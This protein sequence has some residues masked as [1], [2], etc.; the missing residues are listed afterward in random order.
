MRLLVTGGAGFIGSN[1]V[2]QYLSG[3]S[4]DEIINLDLLTYAGN[5][6]NL[7][8]VGDNPKY[9]FVRGD[10]CDAKLVRKLL[11]DCDVIVN[12]AA[13]THV[14]RSF[15]DYMPFV[16]TNV[17]GTRTLLEAALDSGVERF[18]Q[19]SSDEVYGSIIGGSFNESSPLNPTNPYSLTKAAADLLALSYHREQ[20]LPVL[21]S[22]SSNN[23]GPFQ[24]PEKLIP[25]FIT[26]LLEDKKVPLYGDGL[27]V[28]EW[29]HASDNCDAIETLIRKGSA[30]VYNVGSGCERTNLEVTHTLLNLL[31]MGEEYIT[32]V[33]D[34]PFHDR[35]Y[36][37]DSHKMR[38]LGW[39][40][41]LDFDS[42]LKSTIDWYKSNRWWW[43]PLKR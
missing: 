23:Y 38:T 11:R 6:N 25:R 37:L 2:R 27:H 19:V 20:G 3:H 43:E 34:R 39:S 8:A 17:L 26:N 12:F 40:P 22:R 5:L 41:R 18:V 13:E 21:V 7:K 10:V 16:R 29:I 4:E 33:A 42:C 35:R 28:R 14:D 30:G 31:K 36:S 9:S 1:F 24:N 32:Y 15:T